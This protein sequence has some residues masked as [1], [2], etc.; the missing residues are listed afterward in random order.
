MMEFVR[1]VGHTLQQLDMR[2]LLDIL[3][4][5]G[6]FYW[7]LLLLRRTTAMALLRGAAIVLTLAVVLSHLFE[8]RVLTWLLR[9][10]F[11]GLLIAVPIIFQPE[12]R[13]ALERLGRTS[14]RGLLV[15]PDYRA[16]IDMVVETA[17]H[18]ARQRIGALI[19]IERETGLEEFL[20]T[21]T[22][23]D[24]AVSADLLEA[25]FQHTSPLHD[26]A[27]IIRDNRI[28]AAGCMLPLSAGPVPVHVGT[29]HRAGLGITEQSDAI[30]IIVSEETGQIGLAANGRL[31]PDLDPVRLRAF[32]R[33]LLSA[34]TVRESWEQATAAQ[35]NA[36]TLPIGE[37][38]RR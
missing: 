31:I 36:A 23:L 27:V 1:T 30:S 7:L 15:R 11:T 20:D 16:V 18:L 24:A 6:L 13:R 5:A 17:T 33:G 22:R 35:E 3:I 12:I 10:S 2:S 28:M 38:E 21:G 37:G 32:L 14:A 4:I 8:L 26:G 29:R 19:V 34:A 25:I 9:N